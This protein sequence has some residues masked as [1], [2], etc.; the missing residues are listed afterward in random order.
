[1][2]ALPLGVIVS[3]VVA[4][5]ASVSAQSLD[6]CLALARRH[7]PSLQ[8]AGAG[9]SRAEQAIREAR[10]ALSPTLRL[11]ASFVRN[12]ESQL[13]VFPLPGAAT[14]QTIK[15]GSASTLDV[16]VVG[17]YT[18]YSGGRN[19]ALVHAAEDGK[20]AQ[21]H[22]REQAD[23]DLVLRVSQAFYRAIAAQRLDSAA[24]EAIASARAHRATSAARVAAGVAPRLDSLRARVD[25]EQRAT[26]LVRADEAVRV[27]RV[28]LESAIGTPLE[29]TSELV[30]PG[31]P[32]PQ[33][34]DASDAIER[35]RRQR[36]ELK[37]LDQ[38]LRENQ[39]R[40]SAARAAHRPTLNL[41]A[42]AQYLG[43]NR[44]EDYWDPNEAGLRTHKLFAGVG[45]TMP[46]YDA[47]LVAARAGEIA[48][49]RSA[50]E[51]RRADA[52]L[53]IRREVERAVSDLRVAFAASQSDSGRVATAREALRIAEAGYR[54]G[55]STG[56]DVRDAEAALAD[57]RAD[58][59]QATMDC[60]TA[61]ASLDHATGATAGKEH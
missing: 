28:E 8:A 12:S 14:P 57:A 45:L 49:D 11:N 19:A 20:A 15:L 32:S 37:S 33:V 51:A 21:L 60:W 41:T 13:A 61:R 2:K 10:A 38:T 42:T 7:A 55:S 5:P 18:L 29:A 40:Y 9:V 58:E 48:A 59:A 25:L 30:D 47:G 56:T 53:G 44:D 31:R 22:D 16:R 24:R 50:L 17:E 34:P 46:L 3:L 23:A 54:G 39:A 43:P 26:A 36:P 27:T 6:A 35:A 52:E 1:V 4:V